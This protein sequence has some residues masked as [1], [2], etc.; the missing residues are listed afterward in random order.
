[1]THFH[2]IWVRFT[3]WPIF[4]RYYSLLLMLCLISEHVIL[5]YIAII[6]FSGFCIDRYNIVVQVLSLYII[7]VSCIE[8][9]LYTMLFFVFIVTSLYRW[10][11]CYHYRHCYWCRSRYWIITYINTVTR[12]LL[13]ILL[14]LH[15]TVTIIYINITFVAVALLLFYC[16]WYYF[17]YCYCYGCCYCPLWMLLL[18]IVLASLT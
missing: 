9:L 7:I 4:N 16:C 12:V 11:Y 6:S 3:T 15:C 14:I 5:L 2:G 1:M 13:L 10:C 18:F 8:T 17:S